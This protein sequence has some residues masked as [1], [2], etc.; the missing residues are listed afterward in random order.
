MQRMPAPL[1]F[2][3]ALPVPFAPCKLEYNRL[4]RRDPAGINTLRT[5]VSFTF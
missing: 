4:M 3:P 1:L 2:V 5:Q